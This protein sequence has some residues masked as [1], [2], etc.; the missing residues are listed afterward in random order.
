MIIR[1]KEVLCIFFVLM[2]VISCRKDEIYTP[3]YTKGFAKGLLNGDNWKAEGRGFPSSRGDGF[4]ISFLLK[5]QAGMVK[6]ELFFLQVPDSIGEFKLFNEHGLTNDTITG[7]FYFT[8][9]ADDDAIEDTYVVDE[10]FDFNFI[11][12]IE[13]N[14]SSG[15][16]NGAFNVKL[17]IEEPKTNSN[18]PDS[19]HIEFG[20]IE[21]FLN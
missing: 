17:I 3:D 12:I 7:C 8:V 19:L 13:Y 9:P 21:L 15:K 14:E 16:L 20:E 6:E 5:N 1:Y 10:S 18:N 2:L 11:E 4:D